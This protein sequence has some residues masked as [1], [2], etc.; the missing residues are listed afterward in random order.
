MQGKAYGKHAFWPIAI[1]PTILEFWL[2]L[3]ATLFIGFLIQ[4]IV[5]VPSPLPTSYSLLCPNGSIFI[6][7]LP[8]T[9]R[10]IILYGGMVNIA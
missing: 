1:H 5:L 7:T 8:S 6:L 2:N 10:S 9:E 3:V 4:I